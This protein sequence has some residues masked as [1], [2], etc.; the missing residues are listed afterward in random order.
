M[1][2]ESLSRKLDHAV[3]FAG[4][5]IGIGVHSTGFRFVPRLHAPEQVQCGKVVVIELLE[6][7]HELG[8]ALPLPSRQRK[9]SRSP[10]RTA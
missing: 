8:G 6:V 9:M 7:S 1:Q 4:I 2:V 5:A 10:V 3:P